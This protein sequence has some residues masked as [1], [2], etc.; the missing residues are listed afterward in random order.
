MAA[1]LIKWLLVVCAAAQP[2][3]KEWRL[4]GGWEEMGSRSAEMET[5]RKT[6]LR[7][8]RK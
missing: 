1:K 8:H 3:V 2:P 6:T 4:G 7:R 5:Q